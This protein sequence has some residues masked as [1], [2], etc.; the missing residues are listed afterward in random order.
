MV[1]Q[2]PENKIVLEQN[3]IPGYAKWITDS[4]IEVLSV[5]GTIGKNENLSDY[6]KVI[7]IRSNDN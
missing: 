5:P 4:S 1:V 6:K 3:F 7:V 2:T